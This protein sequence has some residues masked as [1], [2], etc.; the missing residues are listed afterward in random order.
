ME[1]FA[2][3]VYIEEESDLTGQQTGNDDE[4]EIDLSK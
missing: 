1:F 4:R 2:R 3:Q